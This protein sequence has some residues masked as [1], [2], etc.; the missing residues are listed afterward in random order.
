MGMYLVGLNN[1]DMDRKNTS[2]DY[3]YDL[4]IIIHNFIYLTNK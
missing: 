3:Y 2:I 4:I 1:M